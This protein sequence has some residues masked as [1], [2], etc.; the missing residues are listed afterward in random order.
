MFADLDESIRQLLVQRGGLDTAEVDIDFHTP[1]REWAAGVSKPTVNVYLYD[2]RENLELREPMPWMTRNG[3]NNTA[4]RSRPLV[5]M[6]VT[7]RFTTFA[8]APE[9]EHRLLSH[10]L[11]TLFQH[12]IFPADLLQGQVAGQQIVTTAAQPIGPVQNLA[13][14]WGAMDNTIKPSIDFR[15]TVAVDLNQETSVGLVL[16]KQA[17]VLRADGPPAPDATQPLVHIGGRVHVA[18]SPEEGLAGVTVRLTERGLDAV[19]D[20]AGRYSLSGLPAGSYTLHLLAPSGGERRARIQVPSRSYD[21]GVDFTEGG[22]PRQTPP[23]PRRPRR[24]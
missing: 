19:T 13:D 11:V 16:T 9:D 6:D 15:L 5:R 20:A 18:G 4:I 21:I 3:P 23:S 7:Y 24:N 22:A 12:P 14:Y 17:R 8:N 1:T 10:I 2:I